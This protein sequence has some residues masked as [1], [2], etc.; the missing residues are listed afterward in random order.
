MVEAL[1]GRERRYAAAMGPPQR[2][3]EQMF[4]LALS[5]GY[6]DNIWVHGI[7]DGAPWIVQQV[8]AVFPKQRFLLDR[9]HL[10]EH[11]HD[12][13]SALTPG[14]RNPPRLG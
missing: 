6:G 8:A 5:D 4:A 7:G 2:A 9:C 12:G 11:L 1:G 10:L 14:D 13:A 3:G